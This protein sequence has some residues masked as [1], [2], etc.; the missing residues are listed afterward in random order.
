MNDTYT[1]YILPVW[2]FKRIWICLL[3]PYWLF[4]WVDL[5]SFWPNSSSSWKIDVLTMN[6][7]KSSFRN[8]EFN[9]AQKLTV[10]MRF[11]QQSFCRNT[12]Y[13]FLG[14]LI[15][16]QWNRQYIFRNILFSILSFGHLVHRTYF[17]LPSELCWELNKLRTGAV[18]MWHKNSNVAEESSGNK[19]FSS[20]LRD[21]S[22]RD[23]KAMD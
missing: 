13:T 10:S 7:K 11:S 5:F 23:P 4:I 15:K 6:T 14:S 22:S 9:E 19:R 18:E 17:A 12:I 21:L 8:E 20:Q 16:N 3:H 2:T 1:L